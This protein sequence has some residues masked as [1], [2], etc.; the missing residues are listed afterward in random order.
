[1][2][3]RTCQ[4]GR[5]PK[6]Y[7]AALLGQN[8]TPRAIQDRR[9]T[10]SL[11]GFSDCD[12]GKSRMVARFNLENC[13]QWALSVQLWRLLPNLEEVRSAESAIYELESAT[14]NSATSSGLPIG[15]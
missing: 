7:L 6:G 10:G 1:M 9:E 11:P 8:Y 4:S 3:L 12:C 14:G 15:T 13:R 5:G 2:S